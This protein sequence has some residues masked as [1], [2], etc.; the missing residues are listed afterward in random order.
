MIELFNHQS[1]IPRSK[2]RQVI[3]ELNKIEIDI[4]CAAE[5]KMRDWMAKILPD[6]KGYLQIKMISSRIRPNNSPLQL[7]EILQ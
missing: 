4:E 2:R 1:Y 5:F 3:E 6:N 7:W